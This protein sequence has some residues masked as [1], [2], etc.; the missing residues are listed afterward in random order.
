MWEAWQAI[1]PDGS[2]T[3]VSY[4][5]YAFGCVGIWLYENIGGIQCCRPGY[6]ESAIRPAL[7]CRISNASLEIDTVYGKLKNNWNISNGKMSMEVSVPANTTSKIYF[8]NMKDGLEYSSIDK[9]L[10]KSAESS[11]MEVGSGEYAFTYSLDEKVLL[12]NSI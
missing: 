10:I 4:N 3:S 9:K 1:L 7:D 11:Y 2:P 5:H 12:I 8:P 6:K